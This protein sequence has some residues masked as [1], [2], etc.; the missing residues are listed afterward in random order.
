MAK[1]EKKQKKAKTM[2]ADDVQ[3]KLFGSLK[4]KIVLLIVAALM[5]SNLAIMFITIPA[6]KSSMTSVVHNY[7]LDLTKSAGEIVDN[8]ILKVSITAFGH[9]WE[10]SEPSIYHTVI[11][12]NVMNLVHKIVRLYKGYILNSYFV[13][14]NSKDKEEK[15]CNA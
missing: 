1:K 14:D 6:V 15:K 8:E 5:I 9:T 7:M 13:K 11:D 4:G 12:G 2:N 10:Y 3:K